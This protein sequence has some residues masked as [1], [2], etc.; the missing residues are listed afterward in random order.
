MTTPDDLGCFRGMMNALPVALLMWIAAFGL[1]FAR[2][3]AAC[4]WRFL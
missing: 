1:I 3:L 4:I 2:A